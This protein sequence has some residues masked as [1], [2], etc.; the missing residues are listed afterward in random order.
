MTALFSTAH[1]S[2]RIAALSCLAFFFFSKLGGF[3]CTSRALMV[4]AV[5]HTFARSNLHL[6]RRFLSVIAG[7]AV[8]GMVITAAQSVVYV[9]A[10]M[11]GEPSDLGAGICIIIVL[12]LFCAGLVVLLLDELLNKGYGLG[13]GISLFIA[14]NICETIV[15]KAFSPT[16]INTGNGTEFEGAMIALFHLLA[17]RSDKFRALKWAFSRNNLPNLTNLFAT[18]LVFAIVIFFQV[19]KCALAHGCVVYA[20]A[21]LYGAEKRVGET[22]R[23]SRRERRERVCASRGGRASTPSPASR[24]AYVCRAGIQAGC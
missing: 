23:R 14:T 22:G 1:R 7:T 13:S 16:T 2:V 5:G 18:V 10:G 11:Y 19:R 12:Q 9:M 6:I 24:T 15:W 17:T 20:R 8:F 3:A 4:D 21:C